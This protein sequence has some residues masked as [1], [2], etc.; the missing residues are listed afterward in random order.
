MPVRVFPDHYREGDA[1]CELLP[2]G[3]LL[4]RVHRVRRDARAFVPPRADPVS[5]GARFDGTSLWPYSFYYAA[6]LPE[7]ALTESLMRDRDPTAEAHLIGY[8]EV[9]GRRLSAVRTT[10]ELRLLRLC[11]ATDVR[12]VYQ[13]ERLLWT[14]DE[15]YAHT[16]VWAGRLWCAEGSAEGLLWMSRTNFP[17]RALMLFGDRCDPVPLEQVPA[18]NVELSEPDGLAAANGLLRPFHAAIAGGPS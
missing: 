11:S 2:R 1:R 3:T 12:A 15:S 6:D 8:E 4:W 9:A 14:V 10:R 13:D 17:E 7:T 18:L 16:R 5:A